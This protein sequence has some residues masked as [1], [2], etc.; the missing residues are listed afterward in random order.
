MSTTQRLFHAE[1][2]ARMAGVHKSTILLAIRRGELHASRT[3][4]RSARISAEDARKY[5]AERNKPI[6]AELDQHVGRMTVAVL[7]ENP[8]IMG[9]VQKAAPEGV[10]LL[11]ATTLYGALIAIGCRAP[12][13]LVV[14]LDLIFM[15]PVS[16][17]RALRNSPALRSAYVIGVGIRDDLFGAARTAGAHAVAVTINDRSLSDMLRKIAVR[18]EEIAPS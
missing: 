1:E 2:L 4:G 9:M 7:T 18:G 11:T 5:L 3:V 13:V 17:I 6:P 8:D 16:L 10:D 12:D 14:D 15:N